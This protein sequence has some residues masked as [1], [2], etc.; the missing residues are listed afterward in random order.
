MA[1]H[2]KSVDN[3]VFSRIK[4]KRGG[5]VFTPTDFVDLGSRTAVGLALM[6]HARAGTIRKLARGLYDVPRTHAQFGKLAPDT[7]AVANALKGRDAI[8]LQPS[9]AYAA[10]ILGLSN[11]VP[12]R[13]VFLTDGPSRRVKIGKQEIVL[14][15]TTP[16]NMAT[17]GRISGTVIQAL[18]WLGQRHVDDDTIAKL[19]RNLKPQDKI[20]LLQDASLAPAWIGAIFHQLAKAPQ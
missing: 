12:V 1:K 8:R 18:R 4:A 17:A 11:Q 14:K 10:N 7:S 20:T 5:W 3:Q 16:R 6:R 13:L 19:R 9:G 2:K 15:Q